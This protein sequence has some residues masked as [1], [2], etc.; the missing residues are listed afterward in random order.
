V[1]RASINSLRPSRI[2]E[3]V[4]CDRLDLGGQHVARRQ[5]PR[6]RTATPADT[7]LRVEHDLAVR[8]AR[9]GLQTR[10]QILTQ[11]AQCRAQ[12]RLLVGLP[13]RRVRNEAEALDAAEMFTLDCHFA[14]CSDRRAHFTLIAQSSYKQSRTSIDKPL[15]QPLVQDVGK[16]VLDCPRAFLPVRRP[17]D[18]VGTM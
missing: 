14:R 5:Q 13:L 16:L 9:E 6:H 11:R 4:G 12:H 10:R 15:H 3:Q 8:A 2:R 17:L 1:A 18:P 7:K